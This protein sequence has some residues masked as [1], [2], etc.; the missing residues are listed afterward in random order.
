MGN[1]KEKEHIKK[2]LNIES[3]EE[4][5]TASIIFDSKQYSIRIPKRFA[6][7]L[8]LPNAKKKFEFT[9]YLPSDPNE[10]VKLTGKLVD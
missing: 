4:T 1:N 10:E 3:R 8:G 9:L 7:A 5:E 2:M 6:D